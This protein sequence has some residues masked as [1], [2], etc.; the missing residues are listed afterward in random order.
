MSMW[1]GR[2]QEASLQAFKDFNDSISFDYVLAPYEIT[3]SLA[4]AEMLANKGI[5]TEAE[6]NSLKLGLLGLKK[7]LEANPKLPVASG[8]EDIHGWIEVTLEQRIGSVARKLHTGRSRND[9]VATDLRLY[10]REQCKQ[11]SAAL[12]KVIQVLIDFA[13]TW[14]GAVM[15]GY[16]HLQRAQPILV[17]H[18][19]LAYVEMLER[20]FQRLQEATSRLNVSPLGAGA[21]AGS[22]MAINRLQLAQSLGFTEPS[23]NS[24]D[25]VSDRDFVVEI[26]HVAS[27]SMAHLSRLS[28]DI[29]FYCS[30]EAGYFQLSDKISSGS[31]LMPQKKN[32][33]V[34]ELVRG[35]T[36]R[37]CGHLQSLL[38]M[39]KG[40]PLAYNK[41][42]QEDKEAFFDAVNQWHQCLVVLQGSIPEISVNRE[43]TL[44]GAELGYSNATDLADYLV[45]KGIPFRDAHDISGKLVLTAIEQS[46]P[47]EKLTLG[48]MQSAS[49]E[50]EKDVYD[51]LT[52]A[53]SLERRNIFGGTA[54]SQV[55]EA[56]RQA[57]LRARGERAGIAKVRQATL[58]DVNAIV[59]LIQYWVKEGEHL[60]RAAED[61]MQAIHT[62]TVAEYEGEVVGCGALYVYGTGLAEIRSL[63]LVPEHAGKG[64]G[65]A[66]VEFSLEQAR[67][68]GISRVIVLTRKPEFFERIGFATANKFDWPEKVMKDCEICPK[69]SCCDETGLEIWITQRAKLN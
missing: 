46:I 16:T 14:E 69:K 37:V 35:K 62:F 24:L 17:S 15:P 36:G 13:K 34:F 66:M 27:L 25:A 67:L 56:I 48:E 57:Q 32:P 55:K 7:E 53:S 38:M 68:L 18:W 61:I 11:L 43:A 4:W 5:L 59:S 20:D 51:K 60:P 42:F 1:G 9:L 12:A 49:K 31:S 64:L 33:D 54:P 29:V 65:K 6:L 41:D 22:G 2:F 63:G 23:R 50:I 8:E 19:A 58:H 10:A 26:V 28:E 47:L 21:L 40:T 44:K 30:G 39:L 45:D 52:I 3:A